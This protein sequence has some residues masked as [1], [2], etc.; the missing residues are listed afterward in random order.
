MKIQYWARQKAKWADFK[1]ENFLD[2]FADDFR[3]RCADSAMRMV[4][5]GWVDDPWIVGY[6]L[7]DSPVLTV[8]MAMPH[9]AGFFHK[10][11]PG[12]TTW[13]VRLRNLG[14]EAPGKQA[15]V[16]LMEERYEGDVSRFNDCYN[17]A[18]ESWGDLAAAKDWRKRTDHSGNMHEERDNHAFLLQILDRCWGE[19]VAAIRRHDKHHIIFGDTL[20]MNEPLSDDIIRVYARHFPVITYQY[21]G[22]T[23]EDHEAVMNRFRR[24][25]PDKPMFSADSSWSVAYPPNVPSPLGPQ[26]ANEKV[27]ARQFEEVYHAAFARH[28]FIGWGWCGWMDKWA[29]AEPDMQHGGLQDAFGNWH[30]PIA[31]TMSQ[32]SQNIYEIATSSM[33]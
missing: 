15:Y 5:Q 25:A 21:Y 4:Q 23:W 11:L 3:I 18:F 12:I 1:E 7:T 26:C 16:A 19:Q 20:N 31:D 13:E 28:D 14:A 10:P 22:A 24:V 27:R 2:V 29:V 6:G 9:A 8:E 30:Q 33:H 32:F 17:T